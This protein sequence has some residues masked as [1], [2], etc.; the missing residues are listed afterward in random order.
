MWVSFSRQ[1]RDLRH[2]SPVGS[3][4]L[5]CREEKKSPPRPAGRSAVVLIAPVPFGALHT[6]PPVALPQVQLAFILSAGSGSLICAP[7][8]GAGLL[9][10]SVMI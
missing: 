2:H 8:T 9:F 4:T 3:A 7:V 5:S 1:H 10:V 6:A